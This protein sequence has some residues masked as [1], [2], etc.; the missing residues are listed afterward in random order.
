VQLLYVFGIFAVAEER[1]MALILPMD[2][3]IPRA[4]RVASDHILRFTHVHSRPRTKATFIDINSIVRGILVVPSNDNEVGNEYLIFDVLD[5]DLWWRM[6]SS[7][8]TTDVRLI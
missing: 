6:R 7:R 5:E 1:Y 4:E 2:A 8:L 3:S